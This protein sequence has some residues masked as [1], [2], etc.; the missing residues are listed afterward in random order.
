MKYGV[1]NSILAAR[2]IY[3]PNHKLEEFIFYLA[4]GRK[5]PAIKLI[6]N[7]NDINLKDSKE[8]VNNIIYILSVV[9][10]YTYTN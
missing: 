9:Y 10:P 7:W 6:K 8:L 2:D 1:V 4:V 5:I 3:I